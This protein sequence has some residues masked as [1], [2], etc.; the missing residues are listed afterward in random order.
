MVTEADRLADTPVRNVAPRILVVEDDG[1][2]RM[3]LVESLIDEGYDILE[4]GSGDE[5]LVLLDQ[6][7]MLLLTDLQLPGTVDGRAL[8]RIARTIRPD[9][10]VLY[11]SGNMDPGLLIGRYDMA[12]AKPYQ[13]EKICSAVRSLLAG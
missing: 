7:V 6:S 9:L 3:M 8:A 10:P 5:A 4:A 13:L 12:I 2:I 11:T 1:L